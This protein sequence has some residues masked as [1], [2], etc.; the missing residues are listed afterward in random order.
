MESTKGLIKLITDFLGLSEREIDKLDFTISSLTKARER[1]HLDQNIDMIAYV[2]NGSA[3]YFEFFIDKDIN[4]VTAIKLNRFNIDALY[5]EI[6]TYKINGMRSKYSN[7]FFIPDERF[8]K[9]L[10]EKVISPTVPL[11]LMVSIP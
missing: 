10:V 1:I 9:L 2:L 6:S 5:N 4:Q 8:E 3:S 7:G 11:S